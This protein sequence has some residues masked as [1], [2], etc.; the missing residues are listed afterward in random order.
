MSRRV[1]LQARPAA[2][3]VALFAAVL[4]TS[5]CSTLRIHQPQDLATAKQAQAQFKAAAL[6]ETVGAE[7]DRLGKVLAEELYLVEKHTLARRDA[8]LLY[9]IGEG[10]TLE[11]W[12]FLKDDIA[13]RL[14]ELGVDPVQLKDLM[15]LRA[16]AEQQEKNLATSQGNYDVKRKMDRTL[17]RFQCPPSPNVNPPPADSTAR[18][19]WDDV[20]KNCKKYLAIWPLAGPRTNGAVIERMRA[21]KAATQAVTQQARQALAEAREEYNDSLRTADV[22]AQR[23]ARDSARAAA[24][25]LIAEANEFKG[26]L[27]GFV[28]GKDDGSALLALGLQDVVDKV[29]AADAELTSLGLGAAIPDLGALPAVA[30][31]EAT[32]NELVAGLAST[33]Q[34]ETA[35]KVFASLDAIGAG[36]RDPA[37]APLTA[38]VLKEKQIG[39]DITAARKR[40]AFFDKT[41]ALLE[42]QDEAY[43]LELDFLGQAELLRQ[44]LEGD[45]CLST[46]TT[47]DSDFLEQLFTDKNVKVVRCRERVFRLL[48]QYSS[49]WTLGRVKSEQVDYRLIALHHESALDTSEIAFQKWQSILGLPIDQLVALYATGLKPEDILSIASALGIG[50][51]AVGVN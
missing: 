30:Q 9:I 13:K 4:L 45:G 14:G 39:L 26:A 35:T 40:E 20:A 24:K 19:F 46:V 28:E 41:L 7:R 47:E 34:G 37:G 27:E 44:E 51:I 17:P 21:A 5:G 31:L 11:V 49:A 36:L 32:R 8:R 48:V 3:V 10:D 43:Q 38:L 15:R 25:R 29:G 6:A 16:Q 18:I 22:D 50:A 23:A 33:L 2:L 12:S 42:E 1:S